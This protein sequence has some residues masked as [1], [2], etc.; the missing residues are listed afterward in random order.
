MDIDC[1]LGMGNRNYKKLTVQCLNQT[2]Y[3]LSST[4]EKDSLV[5]YYHQCLKSEKV[6]AKSKT[7]I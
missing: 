4:V 2:L 3:F 5:L 7:N 1:E 6:L